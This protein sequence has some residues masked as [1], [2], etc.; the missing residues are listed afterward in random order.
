[1][2][3]WKY[4]ICALNC[5]LKG[6]ETDFTKQ[7]LA[8]GKG[9]SGAKRHAKKAIRETILGVTKPAIRRCEANFGTDLRRGT[10]GAEGLPGAGDQGL[11]DLLRAR[12]A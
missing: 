11:S 10:H 12:Q 7:V 6:V 5:S 1:L 3:C 2:N 8:K 4:S 9:K